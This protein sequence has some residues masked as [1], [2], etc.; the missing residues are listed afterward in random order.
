MKKVI[1]PLAILAALI[2]AGGV[3]MHIYADH[4]DKH[5]ISSL[6]STIAT[7][8]MQ[9]GDFNEID[10]S[11]VNVV[12]TTGT[13][14]NATFTAPDNVVDLFEIRVYGGE[15]KVKL[16]DGVRYNHGN[17]NATLTVSSTML[18]EVKASLSSKVYVNSDITTHSD[19]KTKASTSAEIVLKNITC[20]DFDCEL[21]TSANVTADTVTCN[22]FDYESSTSAAVKVA[23]LNAGKT[24]IEGTTSSSAKIGGGNLGVVDFDLS[25]S[26]AITANGTISRGTASATT[27]ASI[28]CQ[29][30]NLSRKSASTGGHITN[31]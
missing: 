9:L 28:K 15:L 13:P 23:Y 25:T 18:N 31:I 5:T 10:A 6:S 27:G 11:R 19:F 30:A 12:Y 29:T 2:C 1:I 21:S 14:G 24:D 16:K 4:S 22:K 26:A 20:A 17:M 8:S 7:R 3:S